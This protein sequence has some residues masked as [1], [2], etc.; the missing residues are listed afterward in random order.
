VVLINDKVSNYDNEIFNLMI[1]L[2]FNAYHFL[3]YSTKLICNEIQNLSSLTAQLEHLSYWIKRINQLQVKPGFAFKCNRNSIHDQLSTWLVEELHFVEKK[4]QLTLM[5]PPADSAAAKD[6][7]KVITILSVQ[8]LAYTIRIFKEAGIITNSNQ[9]ELMRFFSKHFSSA[10][11]EN[12]SPASL[13]VKYY[14]LEESTIN[15]IQEVLS[16][17]TTQTR[18]DLKSIFEKPR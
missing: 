15:S 17:L 2:N 10:R 5:I 14:N 7:F 18:K 12:V 8:Q 1:Y 4:K 16:L 11:N 9:S 13:R 3:T 6:D